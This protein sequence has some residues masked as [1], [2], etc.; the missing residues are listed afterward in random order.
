[1][2]RWLMMIAILL[3]GYWAKNSSLVIAAGVVLVAMAIPYA[4]T[5][6]PWIRANGISLGVT[7]ITVSILI[8]IATGELG[9]ADLIDAFK[10]PLGWFGILCGILVAMLAAKGVA[11]IGSNPLVT[12][13]LTLGTILGVVFFRGVAAG[14]VIA[15]GIVYWMMTLTSHFFQ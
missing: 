12:I 2:E 15:A 8:P 9:M 11:L 7:V 10:S 4:D 14:P 5:L 1:M 13:A 3:I 6:F